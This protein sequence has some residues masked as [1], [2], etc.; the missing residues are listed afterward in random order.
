MAPWRHSYSQ[1]GG[2]KD[3]SKDHSNNRWHW[4]SSGGS[5]GHPSHSVG[6]GQWSCQAPKC[7]GE[8]RK[9]S[10]GPWLNPQSEVTC[11]ACGLPKP[12]TSGGLSTLQQLK[13]GLGNGTAK[14]SYAQAV[15]PASLAVGTAAAAT[16]TVPVHCDSNESWDIST[17]TE[18][19]AAP[20][21]SLALPEEFVAIARLLKEPRELAE[22]WSAEAELGR[23]M[24]QKGK[25]DTSQAAEELEDLKALLALQVKKKASGLPAAT[26]KRVELAER[27][28]RS[29]RRMP[30]RSRQQS[31][32]WSGPGNRPC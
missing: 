3:W 12:T 29:F 2:G 28:W 16:I 11:Q 19:E 17:A 26:Q 18:E 10:R 22:E 23:R 13:S 21:T 15:A 5:Q 9:L 30:T 14:K 7:V 1:N 4:N 20:A 31:Y 32:S 8:C 27:S 24:P 6:N 25:T